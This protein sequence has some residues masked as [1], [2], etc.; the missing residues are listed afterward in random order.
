MKFQENQGWIGYAGTHVP[1][2]VHELGLIEHP[3]NKLI[4]LF[5]LFEIEVEPEVVQLAVK[6]NMYAAR[7]DSAIENVSILPLLSGI[8]TGFMFVEHWTRSL[9]VQP[10]FQNM[11]SFYFQNALLS[12]DIHNS[13][14]NYGIFLMKISLGLFC[15]FR[16][17]AIRFVLNCGLFQEF[18]DCYRF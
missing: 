6:N 5:G 15:V 1:M 16:T 18:W 7:K 4:T 11:Q 12:P 14:P 10:R 8:L 13:V 3:E 17:I 2:F 9:Q